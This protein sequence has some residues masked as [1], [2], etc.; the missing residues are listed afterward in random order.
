MLTE[1]LI[2]LVIVILV[3]CVMGKSYSSV[4][5]QCHRVHAAAF[6]SRTPY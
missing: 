2:N 6:Y 3:S 4:L 1:V 5:C